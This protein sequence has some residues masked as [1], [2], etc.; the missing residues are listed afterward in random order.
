MVFTDTHTHLYLDEFS[1]D[2]DIV[3]ENAFSSNV[4]RLFFPAINSKYSSSMFNLQKKYPENIFLMSGLHP[5]YVGKDFSD[6]I[7][8]VQN[9][10]KNNHIVAIGEI[11]IDLYWDKSNLSM[12]TK[13]FEMQIEIANNNHLPIVIHC[14]ESFDE[15]YNVLINNK[16]LNGGVFHCFSGDLEQANKIIELDMKL[17][18]GG[19][20]TFKNGKIDKF[21]NQIDIKNIVLETD[22]PYLSPAPFRGK[23]NQSANIKIIAEKLCDI[24][25]LS[26]NEI[27]KI[28]THNSK[29]V[30]K[31]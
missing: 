23:R 14:R 15:I 16:P 4:K 3:I 26:L 5:C 28:T 24:Y 11:G 18:I 20:V 6:E 17:G 13:A 10:L 2:I 1:N 7:S 12:Q 19:V 29:E 25:N 27:A 8:L 21:L 22:S 31:V 9:I 30:F